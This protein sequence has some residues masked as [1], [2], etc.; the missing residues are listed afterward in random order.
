MG[1][2]LLGHASDGIAAAV[3]TLPPGVSGDVRHRLRREAELLEHG[4][5]L[6]HSR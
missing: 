4:R 5:L 6:T 1:V 3:K 2:V